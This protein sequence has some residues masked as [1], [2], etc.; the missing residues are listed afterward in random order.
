MLAQVDTKAFLEDV[1]RKLFKKIDKDNSGT[2]EFGE[3]QRCSLQSHSLVSVGS[4]GGSLAPGCVM[5]VISGEGTVRLE[6]V[7][8][9]CPGC[10]DGARRLA[11]T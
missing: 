9:L 7:T 6:S 8:H 11:F 3:L 1:A 10:A 4:I 2:V 5:Y